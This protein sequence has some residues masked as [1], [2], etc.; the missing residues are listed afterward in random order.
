MADELG[1]GAGELARLAVEMNH[2]V[3]L[4][5]VLQELGPLP[6]HRAHI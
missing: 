3:A 2:V 1:G 5:G 6:V 4:T